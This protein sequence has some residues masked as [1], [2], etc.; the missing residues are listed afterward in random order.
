MPLVTSPPSMLQALS[1]PPYQKLWPKNTNQNR[2]T[3]CKVLAQA[4]HTQEAETVLKEADQYLKC[5]SNNGA[6]PTSVMLPIL[7]KRFQDAGISK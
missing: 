3:T 4:L 2:T 7:G 6:F 1:E 5:Y